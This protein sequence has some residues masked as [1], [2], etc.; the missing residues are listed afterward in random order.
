MS[1]SGSHQAL[2]FLLVTCGF[3]VYTVVLWD[4]ILSPLFG[5]LETLDTLWKDT[6][7]LGA[8]AGFRSV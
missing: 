5:R 1:S 7:C 8:E 3:L 4:F 6:G 2:C